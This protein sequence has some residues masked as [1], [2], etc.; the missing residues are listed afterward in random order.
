MPPASPSLD[1]SL[2]GPLSR[3]SAIPLEA[4]NTELVNVA[5][6]KVNS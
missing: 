4:E 2:Q 1:T 6:N 3:K 5:Q